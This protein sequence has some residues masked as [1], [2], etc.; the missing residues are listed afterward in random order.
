METDETPECVEE[1]QVFAELRLG[2]NLVANC[3]SLQ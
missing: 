3:C 1:G 2:R